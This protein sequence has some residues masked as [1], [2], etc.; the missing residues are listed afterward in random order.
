VKRLGKVEEGRPKEVE[1]K[2]KGVEDK[3]LADE[4]EEERMNI[5]NMLTSE[6]MKSKEMQVGTT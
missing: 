3:H 6:D 4:K 1:D 5:V 2:P